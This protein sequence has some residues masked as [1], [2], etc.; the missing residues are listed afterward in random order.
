M[1]H[2]AKTFSLV[3]SAGP[4]SWD[5]LRKH[6]DKNFKGEVFEVFINSWVAPILFHQE[7]YK[8]Y[9]DL[10][11][12]GQIDG[13]YRIRFSMKN[14]Q[15]RVTKNEVSVF[16]TNGGDMREDDELW[17]FSASAPTK[18]AKEAMQSLGIHHMYG[19]EL[20]GHWE[21]FQTSLFAQEYKVNPVEIPAMY[22]HQERAVDAVLTSDDPAV[23]VII[24]MGGGKTRTAAEVV[25]R[26]N[27][28]TLFAAPTR[29]IA[30]QSV[31]VLKDVT[32]RKVIQVHSDAG[33]TTDV[34]LV[35][36]YINAYP[37]LIIVAVYNSLEV[38]SQAMAGTEFALAF[39]DEAHETA[40]ASKPGEVSY[41]RMFHFDD[42]LNIK[43]RVYLTAT[44]RSVSPTDKLRADDGIIDAYSMDDESI[45][46]KVVYERTF[47]ECVE[48]G[49]L[50]PIAVHAMV[51][52]DDKVL[53]DIKL[54]R[55][56]KSIGGEV[57]ALDYSF[58]RSTLRSLSDYHPEG[59]Q[60]ICFVSSKE[61]ARGVE[62]LINAVA[63]HE[64][65]SVEAIQYHSDKK[66]SVSDKEL[67]EFCERER[68]GTHRFI[69]NVRN[70]A[71]G[72][73]NPE[74][75]AILYF[76][77]KSSDIG[78][79]QSVS[80]ASRQ[81]EDKELAKVYIPI[82][83]E[84]DD[85]KEKVI[86][87]T[88]YD[89]VLG[90]ANIFNLFGISIHQVDVT[91]SGS[92]NLASVNNSIVSFTMPLNDF[93]SDV[94]ALRNN[95]EMVLVNRSM[96]KAVSMKGMPCPGPANEESVG[97]VCGKPISLRG[98]CQSHARQKEQ[99][100]ALTP[101]LIYTGI[102]GSPCP[103]PGNEDSSDD[104]C[105]K[106]VDSHGLC[107]AHAKQFRGFNGDSSKLLPLKRM[108]INGGP[109]PAE[110][111]KL[112]VGDTC[113]LPV[114][115]KGFCAG[116]Y[117]QMKK[118]GYTQPIKVFESKVCNGPAAVGESSE[119]CGN[120]AVGQGLCASHNRHLK[121]Y[122]ELRPLNPGKRSGLTRQP[123]PGP[124][125]STSVG[126]TCGKPID[127]H[128]LCRSHAKQ[129]KKNQDLKPL[130]VRKKKS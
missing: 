6:K 94:D 78:W 110:P 86:S 81:R 47:T 130:R 52:G 61:R 121:I 127:S 100:K 28:L 109:C 46:G 105:G 32:G 57:T 64:G 43:K 22:P 7:A 13:A 79:A 93:V 42:S 34:G 74:L 119:M 63:K 54:R 97:D 88:G 18:K 76:N 85:D 106:P 51:V 112:S 90:I 3:Y 36:K 20:R 17:F 122:G 39:A 99:G 120:K 9:P 116:H 72:Y 38:V 53:E 35:S 80:R 103:A 55:V 98:Y 59:A 65:F 50:V 84:E 8:P 66:F 31:Q 117:Q 45:F 30:K 24:A 111:N 27:G 115:A 25:A 49:I 128:G 92:G 10:G 48:D 129:I 70:L 124:P 26:T 118:W 41:R 82:P 5:T 95:V 108:A 4:M 102:A 60:A 58:V 37:D 113:G 104:R 125:N 89:R 56:L 126:A 114:R 73:D 67:Q 15:S 23:Q 71:E 83:I 91:S 68:N 2:T 21:D 12:D 11:S 16:H 14:E 87:K 101:I 75:D 62:K 123:C 40:G 33:G 29:K 1:E 44:R 19:E 77:A 96:P 107:D 69:V